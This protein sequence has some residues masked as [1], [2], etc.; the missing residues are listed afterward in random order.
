MQITR[1]MGRDSAAIGYLDGP[2][3][4]RALTAGIRR[5]FQRRDY[6]N[7]INVFPVP[8]GDTG[9]NMAFTFKAIL[10][11]MHGCP[12][13]GVGEVAD[14]VAEAALDGARG[15]SG[16]IMAQF[17]E[18]FRQSTKG[19]ESLSPKCFAV[20]CEEGAEASW[21]A[22]SEPVAGTLPT[23]LTDFAAEITA[24]VNLGEEDFRSLLKSGRAR[25]ST[26]L[27]N[28]PN[29]LAVLKQHGV[30]DAGGQGFVD[31]LDGIWAFIDKGAVGE[32][33]TGFSDDTFEW[34]EPGP[35][36]DMEIGDH[37]FCTEC[38][39]QGEDL[40]REAIL[41][42]LAALD[43]SSLAVAGSKQ[44]VRVH[45]H[46]NNPADVF[47]ACEQFGDIVQQKADDM[48]GQHRL[49]N[50]S[51]SVAIVVDSAAD[52]PESEVERLGIHIVPARVSF[53]EREYLDGVSLL[54]QEFYRLLAESEVAPRTSQPPALDFRRQYSLLTSHGYDVV[55][56]GLSDA[57]SGTTQ[58][59]RSAASRS[60]D[61]RVI[62]F[63]T[64]NLSAG[65]GLL[66]MVAAEA[67]AKGLN[68]T[69]IESMLAELAP[70]T[71]LRGIPD[72]LS[73]AVRGGRVPDWVGRLATLL[74]ITPVLKARKG[75]VGLSGILLGRG[76]NAQRFARHVARKLKPHVV[77]RVLIAHAANPD[78]ARET[79]RIILKRH[80]EVHSCHITEAGPALGVH[81]GPGGLI[82]GYLPQPGVLN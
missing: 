67:A 19:L 55:S 47:L 66:A 21:S 46:V 4:I 13:A 37:R 48:R 20:A 54:P 77:Y 70:K 64:R 76:A 57:L 49:L 38:L 41:K 9:T 7:R 18:A 78:G 25:A 43:C 33:D 42:T 27:A 40:E 58:A 29:Q 16:A 35:G 52:L 60:E 32:A 63:D 73:F 6:L 59:A 22:M 61:G 17:F 82:V 10:D 28:T 79:R 50:Q 68:A 8:D 24:R 26:S 69:E 53:G 23:V 56:V 72:D 81:L 65:E 39:I 2:R 30:V 14:R 51:G 62:V 71:E 12:D 3:L 5:L 44:R 74:R 80:G 1:F 11:A 31:L 45:I 34:E 15:N 36:A 75:V